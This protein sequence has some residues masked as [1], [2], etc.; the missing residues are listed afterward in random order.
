MA[1]RDNTISGLVHD[2]AVLTESLAVCNAERVQCE[3]DLETTTENLEQCEFN[4]S[5]CHQDYDH[6]TL[7]Y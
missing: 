6:L 4:V 7:D 2:N 3:V 1:T 5:Q